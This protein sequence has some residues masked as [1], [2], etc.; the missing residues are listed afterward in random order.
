VA[1]E[2]RRFVATASGVVAA[3]AT[4]A[5]VDAPN[6]IAQPKIQWRLSTTW[7]TSLD[8][9]QGSAQRL[10][11]LVDEATGGRFRIETFADGQ[12]MPAFDCFPATSQGTIEAFMAA[13]S[14]WAAKEPA[15]R[16]SSSRPPGS[17]PP[18]SGA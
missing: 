2:Q 15:M 11:K 10:A 8:V 18:S 4:A 3:A 5:F 7:P 13:P 14:Y 12:I 1:T 6:V 17:S 16:R 9:M